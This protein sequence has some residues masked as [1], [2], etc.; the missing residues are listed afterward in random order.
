MA[1]MSANDHRLNLPKRAVPQSGTNLDLS[2][3]EEGI[4]KFWE[5]HDIFQKTLLK[6]KKGKPF[7]FYEGP[8]TANGNPGIHHFEARAFK[9]AIPRYQTMR[10]RF[11]ARKAGWDTHGLPVEIQVEKELG[12]KTKKEIEKYGIGKFNAKCR[13]SVWRYKEEWDR[14][15]KRIGFWLDLEH[16]YV[17]YETSYIESLWWIIKEFHKRKLLYRDFKVVPW[18]TRC[19]TGLSSHEL[20]LGYRTIKDRSVWVRFRV[21]SGEKRWANTSILSWTTTPWTLPGNV[22]LAIDSDEDYVCI[23]DPEAKRQWIILGQKRF[24]DM[25]EESKFP[26]E[27]RSSLMLDDIDTFKGKELI[28]L[29]Y[30]PLFP[31]KEIASEASHR[32][33][34]ADFVSMEDGSGVVH[35]AVMY[36]DDDYRLGKKIG[37]PTFHTVDEAGYFI[38]A[39]GAGLAGLYVKDAK[40][41]EKIL[42]SL[43]E[44]GLLFREEWY[45]HEY[46]FCWR[47]ETPLLYY[48]REAWWVKVSSM[49]KDLVRNNEK[50]NW[51]PEH[52]KRGR[53]GEFLKEA[54]DWAFSRERY[55]GTPL[56]VWQCTMCKHEEVI[57]SLADFDR[58]DPLPTTITLMRHGEALH[59]VRNI[60]NPVGAANDRANVLTPSGRKAAD[61][62]GKKLR[63]AGITVIVASPSHRAQETARI[64]AK[65]IGVKR[66]ET[67]IALADFQAGA[68]E[69]RPVEEHQ[70]A[71]SRF[72]ERFTEHPGG[73][74]N[75][76]DIRAR[77]VRAILEIK[78]KYQGKHVLVVSHGDPLWVLMAATEGLAEPD[79]ETAQ[80]LKPGAF[81]AVQLHHWPYD[82]G[83]DVN[84]HR[85]FVDDLELACPKC[86]GPMKRVPDVCDVWFDSGG[87]PF[88]EHHFPFAFGEG[89]GTRNKEQGTALPYPADYICEA[90]DQTRGW[91]YTLLAEATLIGR[92]NPYRNVISLGH[93]LDT[94]GQ[95]MSKSKGNAVDPW[96]MI[97]KYGTDAIRW[98]FYTING[99][100]DPKRFD[101]KD[102][103]LKL[104]GLLATL[105]NSL[106]LF[107][108]YTDKIRNSKLEIRNSV[109][110]L[111]QWILAR[112]DELTRGATSRLDAY[113]IVGAARLLEAFI[114][115]DLSNWY[116]RR[117]RRRFQKPESNQDRDAVAAVTAHVLLT[118]AELM[119]PF[120]PFLA[121][122]VYQELKRKMGLKEESIHLRSWPKTKFKVQNAKFRML[123]NGMAEVRRIAALGLAERAKAGIKVRQPLQQLKVKSLEFK[124]SDDL[125][126]LLKDEVNVKEVVI[127]PRI[128]REVL[129]DTVITFQLRQE[130]S[131][132]ELIRNIQ[133]MRRDGGFRPTDRIRIQVEGDAALIDL[134]ANQRAFVEREAGVAEVSVGGKRNFTVERDVPLDGASLWIGIRK[135]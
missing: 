97:A 125:L 5:D 13:E 66:I 116:L 108:T 132:R 120:T 4:L 33:Y 99:P 27:Y 8:P 119:A 106:V 44:R 103:L 22:A 85:P 76:R 68:F 19:Q 52:I 110:V 30:E 121:E 80:Y 93:V 115:D 37:L 69:G 59:N 84:L 26:P 124:V 96:D 94:N 41:D 50:I 12:L 113:D 61:V 127:D 42:Q 6:T 63:H 2:R 57:G 14:F 39:L 48:A 40:T 112:L 10:G 11:V 35:T 73:S 107:D 114:V 100:G 95:K 38:K 131:M 23:P 92:G 134:V 86:A 21:K 129:L 1:H 102:L 51:V 91:F 128:E 49:R 105:W 43:K 7:V 81:R 101:E 3:R 36:G 90:I 89:K 78:K 75:L 83:G 60:V 9:D 130:G 118:L 111:D 31:V 109:N 29:M 126:G 122:M 24:R 79:Y 54:R 18:C 117:S 32:V 133:E 55:W 28:G 56:P 87:M 16:P 34:A 77:M 70:K 82:D 15:T 20:G 17:T 62:A 47:C 104:R 64:V 53:F 25:V 65:T 135:A 58:L 45:E 123:T 46:P 71:F 67:V 72:S 74:E 88:A 98:Y